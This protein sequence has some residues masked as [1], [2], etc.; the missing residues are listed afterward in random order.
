MKVV[1]SQHST[2]PPLSEKLPEKI[3]VSE[4]EA[5]YETDL[6]VGRLFSDFPIQHWNT[7]FAARQG[8][9]AVGRPCA[10]VYKWTW[11]SSRALSLLFISLHRMHHTCK[12]K[13]ALH[14][15]SSRETHT[16]ANDPTCTQ[17]RNYNIAQSSKWPQPANTS[18]FFSFT[19]SFMNTTD[20]FMKEMYFLSRS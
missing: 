20:I 1:T 12:H 9:A 11:K 13:H 18:M 19:S 8:G 15:A 16:H 4:F 14:Y 2:G 10:D 6:P 3:K 17:D 7:V 5:S